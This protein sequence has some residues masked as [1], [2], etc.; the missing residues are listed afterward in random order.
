[1]KFFDDSTLVEM[2]SKFFESSVKTLS[3]SKEINS[4]ADFESSDHVLKV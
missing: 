3:I 1:M 4:R 2:F